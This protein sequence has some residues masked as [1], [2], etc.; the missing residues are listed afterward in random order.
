MCRGWLGQRPGTRGSSAIDVR[1]RKE[2]RRLAE[3]RRPKEQVT[4]PPFITVH[5][6]LCLGACQ[7]QV[8]ERRSE[9]QMG[10]SAQVGR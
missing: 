5:T 4:G 8:K 1:A 3:Q 7:G 2:S 9:K 10:L 6:P